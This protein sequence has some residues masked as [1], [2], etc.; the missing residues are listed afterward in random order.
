MAIPLII[1][2][3]SLIAGIY[4]AVKGFDAKKLY[5]E[6]QE[7]VEDAENKYKRSSK[8]LEN[9][10]VA[11]SSELESLGSVRLVCQDSL[12]RKFVE[13]VSMVHSAEYKQIQ[14]QGGP[15][16]I[17]KPEIDTIK[18]DAYKAADLLKDGIGAVSTGVL[19]GMGAT[20]LATSIGV[21]ST[22]TAIGTLSGAAATNATLAWLG[23]GSLASGGM[24]VAGGSAVLGGAIAGPVIAVMGYTA[25]KKAEEAL[26]QATDYAARVDVA[27]EHMK[28]GVLMLQ[29][30][31][32][33]TQEVAQTTMAVGERFGAIIEQ[34]E[35]F[36][37]DRKVRKDALEA[38]RRGLIA[39]YKKKNVLVR[40][41]RL[42]LGKRPK[43]SYADP[44]DYN[45]FSDHEK[46][47][48]ALMTTFAT[49]FNKILKVNILDD[50]G[51]VSADSAAVADAGRVL[52]GM[53]A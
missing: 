13:L 48:Y 5:A 16:A 8:K 37:L 15:I 20:G 14:Q 6:A 43:F 36:V 1:G 18:V 38:E 52:I 2:G 31:Q 22:G 53:E 33:R 47:Q 12:M 26:T 35:E 34:V 4:G 40:L 23:G 3:A 44:L 51:A 11:T 21:A 17:S 25:A 49:S 30:I 7:L 41:V 50:T 29:A 9:A 24:G 19:A 32:Q 42:L 39:E 28:N 27:A 46:K 45:Q 10:R